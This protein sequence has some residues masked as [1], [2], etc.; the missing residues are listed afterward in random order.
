M[1]RVGIAFGIAVLFG[2]LL[3]YLMNRYS[4]YDTE[5]LKL[6]GSSEQTVEL[7]I[8]TDNI[9]QMIDN[10]L[11]LPV[12]D[13]KI[14]Y[15]NL[16][17]AFCFVVATV[18]SIHMLI[19]KLFYKKFFEEPE[20]WPA[21]RRGLLLFFTIVGLTF[22]R[23]IGGLSWNNVLLILLLP[24]ILEFVAIKLTAKSR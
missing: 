17:L 10:G 21:L 19:D 12:I 24:A 15:I 3:V 9:G 18:A 23:L 13:Y 5:K 7:S 2:T 11:L 1:K 20:L 14:F 8:F 4:P 22:Y 6:L 16:G